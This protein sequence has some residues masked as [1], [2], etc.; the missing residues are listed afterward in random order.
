MS[1]F[2]KLFTKETPKEKIKVTKGPQKRRT[3][4]YEAYRGRLRELESFTGNSSVNSIVKQLGYTKSQ[5]HT[6]HT[7]KSSV[8]SS[9]TFKI[10]TK[11]V[12]FVVTEPEVLS[13]NHSDRKREIA[14]IDWEF[15][16]ETIGMKDHL[17][18]AIDDKDLY[19]DYLNSITTLTR[20]TEDIYS[21]RST[22]VLLFLYFENGVLAGVDEDLEVLESLIQERRMPRATDTN[23]NEE[24]IAAKTE[25]VTL[26]NRLLEDYAAGEVA[27]PVTSPQEGIRRLQELSN[28][29][30][31][32]L[33]DKI[34][35]IFA[36]H[37]NVEESD[38]LDFFKTSLIEYGEGLLAYYRE[39]IQDIIDL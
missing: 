31:A 12:V 34:I 4:V 38:E 36:E 39:S 6:V 17:E 29:L 21:S 24:L 11:D 33:A 13:F 37:E 22:N 30:D 1:F 14:E 20:T 16:Y 19:F 7:F 15:E 10:L 2:K 9:I 18:D 35:E 27:D 28:Q 8:T 3:G 26:S 25:L 32:R 23:M 5:V